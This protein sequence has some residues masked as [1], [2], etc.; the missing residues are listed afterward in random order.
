MIKRLFLVSAIL[1]LSAFFVNTSY[2]LFGTETYTTT[3]IKIECSVSGSGGVSGEVTP[4]GGGASITGSG[5]VV[6]A[7]YSGRIKSC[8]GWAW[9]C[10]DAG[11][12]PEITNTT[13]IQP[14]PNRESGSAGEVVN[15]T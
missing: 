9:G 6:Y 2:G 10:Y 7:H 13:P 4:G 15:H 11:A 12:I 1:M 14:C 8:P 5:N 3:I